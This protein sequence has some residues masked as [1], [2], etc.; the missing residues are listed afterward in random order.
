[1]HIYI[2]DVLRQERN[3]RIRLISS[4]SVDISKLTTIREDLKDNTLLNPEPCCKLY[5]P[6]TATILTVFCDVTFFCTV[7][8]TKIVFGMCPT[9]LWGESWREWGIY[10][11]RVPN[12][13]AMSHLKNYAYTHLNDQTVYRTSA[14]YRS[15]KS[16]LL[17]SKPLL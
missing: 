4:S 6:L 3:T 7:T 10:T 9:S 16:T 17:C 11:F 2:F 14:R 12:P 15:F 1:M 5:Q 13:L 8:L